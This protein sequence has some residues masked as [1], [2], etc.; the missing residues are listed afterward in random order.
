MDERPDEAESVQEPK[1]TTPDSDLT[2]DPDMTDADE[3]NLPPDSD[4]DPNA[5]ED[6]SR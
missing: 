6:A 3:A 5:G 4:A 1:G 2:F